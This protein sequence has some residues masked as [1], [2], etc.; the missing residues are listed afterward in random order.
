[1]R[2]LFIF[3][4]YIYN[5]KLYSSFEIYETDAEK[6]IAMRNF[7]RQFYKQN[8]GCKLLLGKRHSRAYFEYEVNN[9]PVIKGAK[10]GVEMFVYYRVISK[11]HTKA[12]VTKVLVD[13][14]TDYYMRRTAKD[15]FITAHHLKY[16]D[17]KLD[18][19]VRVY[20]VD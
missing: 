18:G 16:P 10:H 6:D 8:R 1:M 17:T 11:K 14:G 7:T 20:F 13:K 15:I 5:N 12:Y 3:F 9:M 4:K 2:K 19:T